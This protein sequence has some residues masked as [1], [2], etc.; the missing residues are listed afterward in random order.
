MTDE[1]QARTPD[2]Q[3]DDDEAARIVETLV[4]AGLAE[5]YE[6]P[7]GTVEVRLTDDG[8]G[9]R[10]ALPDPDDGA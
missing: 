2:E 6:R 8:E 10:K 4:Q 5:T 9:L 3:D 1:D 7:D